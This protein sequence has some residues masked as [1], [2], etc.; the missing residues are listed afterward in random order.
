MTGM[1]P[2]TPH[3]T[4]ATPTKLPFTPFGVAVCFSFCF[5]P[6]RKNEK[7]QQFVTNSLFLSVQNLPNIN[8]FNFKKITRFYEEVLEHSQKSDTSTL[9]N[10]HS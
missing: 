8:S 2:T 1:A 6:Q 5:Q 4:T 10:L 9:H 3:H 7:E